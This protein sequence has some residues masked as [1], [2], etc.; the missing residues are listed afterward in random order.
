MDGQILDQPLP[1]EGL[2][3]IDPFLLIHHWQGNLPGDEHP[4]DL[5]V[6]PHPH[7]GF[8][9]VTFVVKGDV[10]HRDSR[11]N[12]SIVQRGGVQW[13]NAGMGII[14]SERPS[15]KLAA[16]GGQLE[17]IQ[18]WI[19]TPSALKMQQPSYQ[20]L[21]SEDI[22]TFHDGDSKVDIKVVAGKFDTLT[23]QVNTTSPLLILWGTM[24]QGGHVQ[25]PVPEGYECLLYQ[26]YGRIEI[27]GELTTHVK[28]MTWFEKEGEGIQLKCETDAEFILLSGRPLNEPVEQQGPFVMSDQTEIMRAMRDYRMGKMGVLIEEF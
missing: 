2:E 23:S 8:S 20:A 12:R 5:G 16:E 7:R 13:M 25:I 22:P 18:V 19:N 1:Y 14:H 28:N 6:G 17:L 9:P 21:A 27:N 3:R 26:L 15:K 24:K 4:R 11:G 10:E